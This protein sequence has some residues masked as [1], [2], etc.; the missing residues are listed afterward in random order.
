VRKCTKKTKNFLFMDFKPYLV[1][2]VGVLVALIAYDMFVKKALKL[3]TYDM[4][5]A[6]DED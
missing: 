5:E 6:L 2:I 4:Y 1:V 3:D